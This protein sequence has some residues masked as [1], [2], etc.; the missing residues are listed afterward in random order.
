MTII[1]VNTQLEIM[2]SLM[3]VVRNEGEPNERVEID[4]F[5]P[6]ICPYCNSEYC[7]AITE[8]KAYDHMIKGMKNK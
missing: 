2:P 7:Y 8:S 3:E 6:E 5:F 1:C 4:Y